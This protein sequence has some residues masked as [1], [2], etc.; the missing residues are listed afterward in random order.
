MTVTT[1]PAAPVEQVSEQIH[2][3]SGH[4]DLSG[5][6]GQD[7]DVLARELWEWAEQSEPGKQDVRML[8][9]AQGAEGSLSRS[10]L[11]AVGPDMP[12]LV[13]S[14][15]GECA[16]QGFEVRT[17]F[18]P[19][20]RTGQG[21]MISVIQVHL[22]MLTADE[23]KRLEAG[24]RRALSDNALVV[25][26][27]EAM[28]QRMK[29]EVERVA[30]LE[31][32]KPAEREEAVAFLQ[33]LSKEHFVFLGC[34]E[35]EFETDQDGH[36]L[37]EEP[38]MVEG[39]NLGLLRDEDLN[40]LSREAE[41]LVL[42]PEIGALLAEPFPLIVAKSTLMSRVHRRVACDYVGVKKY[43]AQGRVNGEVRFLGLFTAEAYDEPAREIPFIRRRVAKIIQASGATP[44][45]HTE[46]ALANLL[47][48]WPR[49]ELFQTQSRIL[50]PIIM[51]ALHL[52]GRPRTRV[53]IRRDQF[54]RYVTA[55]VYVAREA[56]D[57][58][59]RQ[60]IT[61]ELVTSYKGRITR[62]RP[63]FD[64]E[65][66]VRVHFEIWLNQGHP[67]P[68]AEALEQR[69]ANLA[70]TWDQGFRT[71][72]MGAS[73]PSDVHK[74]ARAFIGAFNAAYRE[75][76]SPEEAV[77]DIAAMADLTADQPILARAFRG[78]DAEADTVRIKIYARNGSIPLSACVPIFEKMGLYVDFETGY[79][80]R[81]AEKPVKDAPETYWIHDLSMRTA[82]GA[83]LL[84]DD[85]RTALEDAFV[86]VWGGRAEN[87]GFNRLVLSAGMNWREAALI[88]TLA[89][90]RR[91]SG[92]EQPQDVQETAL[93]SHPQI[94]RLLLDMFDVRF[95]PSLDMT[96]EA[97]AEKAKALRGDIEDALRSVSALADD[98][99]LRRLADL[100]PAVQ[101]TNYYQTREDGAAHDFISLKIASRELEDLPEPK[102]Y[103]EIFM[104][105]P[106]VEGV[107]LRF[108]PVARGG[109][110][111]SD[112][113]S[114]Y[115]TEVL[116]L[117]K[118]QQVKNAVIVPVGS[119]G[120]FYPKQLADRSDRNAWF[121]S[122]RD[123]YKEFIRSLLGLTDNLV[124]GDIVHPADTVIWD[125]EDPYLV[126]AAD[127][128]T[129]TFSDT[130]NAISEEMGHWL[131]DA[132]ASGGSAGYDHKKMGITA[133]GGWEAVKRHF[134]EMG[135]DIQTEPFTVIGVG[136]MSGD[137]FGNGMLL[138][139]EIRLVAA[140]NHMHVFIDP[141]PDDAARNLSE[142]ERLFNAPGSS[143]ADYDVSLI[144][145][146][147]GVFERSAK[148]IHLTDQIKALT[149][150][151]K[152]A[153]TPDELIHALLKSQADL[154]WF[155]G[156]GTYV[157]A[158]HESH[159]HAGDR[160]NDAIRV[161]AN[162]LKVKVIGEG[163]N[164]GMTQAARIEF[165]LAGGR[166]NTDAIDN[167]AGVDS[168]DH[169]VN[170]KILAAE[171]IRLGQLKSQDRNALLAEMTDDVA[172]LVL[173]HNY[174]QT[175]A[176]TLAEATATYDHDALER[177]MVYLEGRGVLNRELEVLPDTGEMK[178]RAENGQ[179]LTR[180]ELAVLLAWSKITLFDDIVASDIPDDPYFEQVLKGY[181]PSPI[182]GYDEAMQN[183]RLKREIIATI[184]ANRVIDMAGPVAL[185][186]LREVSNADNVAVTRGLAAAHAVL[187]F[188]SFQ[189]EVDALDNAVP[190]EVQTDLRLLASSAMMEAAVWFARTYPTLHVGEMVAKTEAPLNEFK[191]ALASIHSPFPAA[192][193]ERT[194]RA[195]M[196][197]GAPED[198][199][200]WAAAI[201]HFAQ[202]LLVV[203]MAEDKPYDVKEAGEAFYIIGDQ[204]RI[205]R[206]RA[207]AR[208]GLKKGGY[209][210]RVAGRRQIS[211]L[212]RMQAE[213]AQKALDMGGAHQWLDER[214]EARKVLLQELA[215]LGKDRTWTFARFAL[216]AD[217][218]RQFMRG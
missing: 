43:D 195:L 182:D 14:L 29:S 69:I 71:A 119:K 27:F 32:L 64:S 175:F 52:I 102:P 45:G 205:D 82:S 133:R 163:A 189:K 204:L 165:A 179:A 114:D 137:V 218:V 131:G 53:F 16:A 22:P 9:D 86:A 192:R 199:A 54:D 125:G 36:V 89:G 44:G 13:D 87:D 173:R 180:P 15:L 136:D 147:G 11:E 91:Q 39:S 17:L 155:G 140:F 83:P 184:I 5:L 161:D 50:G 96:L 198:L 214:S 160:S 209:W 51:G 105:S 122:G 81:P 153:V 58:A 154:L 48:T 98:Q 37:P 215:A 70:R 150:L 145:E 178:V 187:H 212:V 20:V 88:R 139:P 106:R 19:I 21:Q 211:E 158:A 79:P 213:A 197:R 181:F 10:I 26:D 132:F 31:H 66:L 72:L 183:H 185:L 207:S 84:I 67:E 172:A 166:V 148:S 167:S 152:D 4:E 194:A 127:K 208:E 170:I 157:K 203:D 151:A 77:L 33:W 159:A 108:G 149:G 55:I 40:V 217:A 135:R 6:T 193:I 42:T 68:D 196:K 201:G 74:G 80:V 174:N 62:F 190:A 2:R 210:D 56:Y 104:S 109:L 123:A 118:A 57:T 41:P 200:R 206:L 111:W 85:I 146:G 168:S 129:A 60:R 92:M 97:R 12:F 100:I 171:A 177:L 116:G 78:E 93:A 76:F 117:V 176:L 59:L 34:R 7:L 47:E 143:W 90:Y 115:R 128:G 8:L 142:R 121:E 191:A 1:A 141:E 18:H 162:D 156:I 35:Y 46:K 110:R 103:R 99:V 30:E 202:G 120:G 63:Y 28:R 216:A 49:D 134:R 61:D 38:I 186:R 138:S 126:V 3:E 24:A 25:A 94:A 124:H 73:L 164:L 23:A 169:E 112:R 188:E 101:R 130:A 144:S 113:A 75:A 65:T 107:H 95:D